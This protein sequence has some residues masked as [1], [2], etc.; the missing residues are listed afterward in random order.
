MQ[1]LIPLLASLALALLATSASPQ[2][3]PDFAGR[4][5]SERAQTAGSMGSGWGPTITITQ[6]ANRLTVEYPFYTPYDMQPPLRFTY[7]LD[8]SETQ[9]RVT[10]GRGLQVQSARAEWKGRQLVIITTLPFTN[11]DDGRQMTSEVTRTLTLESPTTLI[12]ETVFGG[13]LGGPST[14]TRTSYHK[15]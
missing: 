8:G 13:A 11:P 2:P 5:T 15:P 1:T 4:W 3:H 12:V 7:A 9:N 6:D 14:T 10:M